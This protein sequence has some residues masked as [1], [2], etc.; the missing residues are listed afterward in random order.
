MLICTCDRDFGIT[1]P[2][3]FIRAASCTSRSRVDRRTRNASISLALQPSKGFW[4]N[5][6][7]ARFGSTTNLGRTSRRVGR[8]HV[9][10]AS[11]SHFNLQKDFGRTNPTLVSGRPTDLGA[12]SCTSRRVGRRRVM[13]VSVSHYN[14]EK[15]FGRTNPMLV[16]R[17]NRRSQMTDDPIDNRSPLVTI[18]K[19]L[20]PCTREA[21]AEGF[22][23]TR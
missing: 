23:R 14:L 6:P 5:E 21:G 11:V 10:R 22:R 19:H 12:A 9:M 18:L 7:N 3:E 1:N 4:Q 2:N 15:D 8:R 17:V 16:S 20:A 13:R